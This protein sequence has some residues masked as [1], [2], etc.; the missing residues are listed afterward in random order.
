MNG[1][2]STPKMAKINQVQVFK[3]LER[4]VTEEAEAGDIVLIN[5]V[6]E[7]GIGVTITDPVNPVALPLLKVDEPT[8]TMN[9]M[10]NTSPLAGK[11]GKFRHQPSNT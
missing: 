2:G 10:V 11:E 3:G 7:V 5:G 6:E 8:L 1:P 4:T 9:F